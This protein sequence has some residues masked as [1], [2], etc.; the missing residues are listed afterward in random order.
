MT[1]QI[2]EDEKMFLSLQLFDGDDTKYIRAYLVDQLG[3]DLTEIDLTN[4]GR[5]LYTDY[6]YEYPNRPIVEVTYVVYDDDSY[7]IESDRY[8]RA[9]DL[10]QLLPEREAVVID[11]S[12]PELV[13]FV[14]DNDENVFGDI[15]DTVLIGEVSEEEIVTPVTVPEVEED[16]ITAFIDDDAL[17]GYVDSEEE[18]LTAIIK[19][20]CDD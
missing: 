3:W 17:V 20:E 8:S 11:T 4:V 12:Q 6:N 14:T 10:F 9:Q 2:K 18:T 5:G 7:S 13:G 19:D 16:T 15:E 1:I